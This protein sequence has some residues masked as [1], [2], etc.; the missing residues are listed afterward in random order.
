[1][2]NK[3]GWAEF[4]VKSSDQGVATHV[5]ASFDPN[6]K[7]MLASYQN[8]VRTPMIA[9]LINLSSRAQWRLP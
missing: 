5:F 4:K 9:L 2:G 3:E 7:G 8:I 1:M 6:L